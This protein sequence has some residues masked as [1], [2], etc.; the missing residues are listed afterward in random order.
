MKK[1][2]YII[3]VGFTAFW[4]SSSSG[5]KNEPK[6]TEYIHKKGTSITAI[7]QEVK[8][9]IDEHERQK[10]MNNKQSIN[11]SNE[12]LNKSQWN[13]LKETTKKIQDRLRIVDFALQAIPTGYM[14][15]LKAKEIKDNQKRILQEIRTA[16]QALKKVLPMQVDFVDDLQMVSRFLTGLVVSYGTINQMER[17]ERQIL[18]NY[19]LE[20]INRLANDSFNT[21]MVVQEVK[22]SWERRKSM[23]QYYI[24]RDKEL[25]GDLIKNIKS[26]NL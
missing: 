17:A 23:F 11:Y 22:A 5:K 12:T 18:L 10:R 20:E 16:P 26:L 8:Y 24:E 9:S 4:L 13:K 14:V 3:A 15:G 25:V 2:L 6:P 7:S 19:A 1:Y 21:L